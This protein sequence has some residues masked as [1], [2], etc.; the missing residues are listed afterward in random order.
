MHDTHVGNVSHGPQFLSLIMAYLLNWK[1]ENGGLG[2]PPPEK[3]LLATLF[4]LLENAFSASS[5]NC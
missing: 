1:K 3:F 4:R 5:S 2:A